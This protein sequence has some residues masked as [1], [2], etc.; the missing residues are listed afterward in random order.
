[1]EMMKR[2]DCVWNWDKAK[3]KRLRDC[4]VF[5]NNFLAHILVAIGKEVGATTWNELKGVLS[6]EYNWRKAGDPLTVYKLWMDDGECDFKIQFCF[7]N[8]D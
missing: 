5:L 3:T 7:S 4:D 2:G 6:G 1:M 8:M